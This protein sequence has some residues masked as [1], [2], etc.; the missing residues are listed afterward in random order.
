MLDCVVFL[1]T[2]IHT[3]IMAEVVS[4]LSWY[5]TTGTFDCHTLYGN[6]GMDTS[7]YDK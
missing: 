6:I 3:G 5:F 2:L 4:D 1:H 7:S